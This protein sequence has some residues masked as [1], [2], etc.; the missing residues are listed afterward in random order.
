MISICDWKP[1]CGCPSACERTES[2]VF[3]TRGRKAGD[4]S[5]IFKRKSGKCEGVGTEER[6]DAEL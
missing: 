5:G 2:G 4:G 1:A 6:E 3:R